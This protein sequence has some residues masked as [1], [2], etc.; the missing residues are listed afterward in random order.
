MRTRFFG[1]A[2]TIRSAQ[3]RGLKAYGD[4]HAEGK[5][6]SIFEPST[7]VIR[8]GQPSTP[9]A[10][11]KMVK[12]QEAENQIIIAFEVDDR[13]P[14]DSDLLI[15]AIERHTTKLGRQP[16]LVAGDAAFYLRKN[17]AAAKRQG[18]KRV[19]IL[20]RATKVRRAKPSKS[21]A[22]STAGRNGAPAVR[23]PSASANAGTAS[24]AVDTRAMTG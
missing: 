22:G 24:P 23:D 8:K 11:G 10:F 12:L 7:E 5:I 13:R 2:E 1:Q 4:P 9:P 16:R 20:N 6:V 21:S 3:A 14:S 19:C 18:V 17:E 15:P